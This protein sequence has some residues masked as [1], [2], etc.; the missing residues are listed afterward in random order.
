MLGQEITQPVR[1]PLFRECDRRANA[2]EHS[3]RTASATGHHL[4]TIQTIAE[5]NILCLVI[6]WAAPPRRPVSER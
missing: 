5:K 1:R 3:V 4:R 6:G 2:V